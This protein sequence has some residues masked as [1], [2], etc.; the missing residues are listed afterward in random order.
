MFSRT[1]A[2]PSQSTEKDVDKSEGE[3]KRFK[4]LKFRIKS[5]TGSASEKP[6]NENQQV[7]RYACRMTFQVPVFVPVHA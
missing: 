1:E 3:K 6:A 7:L 5:K 2:S 4:F